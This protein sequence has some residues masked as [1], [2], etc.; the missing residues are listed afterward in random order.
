M[1]LW[2]GG[3]LQSFRIA[4]LP[5][6]TN[7]ELPCLLTEHLNAVKCCLLLHTDKSKDPDQDPWMCRLIMSGTWRPENDLIFHIRTATNYWNTFSNAT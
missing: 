5:V 2:E 4:C 7:Q 1:G 6:Q 3:G